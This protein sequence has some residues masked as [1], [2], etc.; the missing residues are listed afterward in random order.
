MYVLWVTQSHLIFLV[1][2]SN[3]SDM[4]TLILLF[5]TTPTFTNNVDPDQM[6]SEETI[7]SGSTLFVI[8]F[9]NL[10]KNIIWCNLIGWYSEM[11]VAY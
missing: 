4:L 6:A 7:W 10:N 1:E 5:M 11:G 3:F 2:H 8:Q 9:V